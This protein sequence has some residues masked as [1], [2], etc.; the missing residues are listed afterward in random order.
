MKGKDLNWFVL[1]LLGSF[2]IGFI[3]YDADYDNY[4]DIITFL[5][6]MIGFKIAS[7]SILFNSPLKKKLYDRKILKY[8]TELHR[9]RDYYRH[10]LL[11]EVFSIVA[12]FTLPKRL[13]SFILF[14]NE[15]VMGKHL[16]VLPI[17]LGTVFCFYKITDDL[18]K[19]FVY[20][21]NIKNEE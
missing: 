8:M 2:I 7:L 4:S 9:L 6:I 15:I 10:S 16:F 11:F 3:I 19:I 1:I 14:E 17:I 18:L 13:F 20:P 21:T 5:S 12:L